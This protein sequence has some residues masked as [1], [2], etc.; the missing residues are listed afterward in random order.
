MATRTR[1]RETASVAGGDARIEEDLDKKAVAWTFVAKVDPSQFDAERSLSNNA[2]F[3]AIDEKRVE[4]YTEAMKRGDAFP[5]VVAHK[6]G[7]LFVIT[8][9]NH[10]LQAAI[11]AGKPL[12]V[13]D[14]TGAESQVIVLLSFEANTRHGLPTSEEERI[15]QALYLINNGATIPAAAA[16]VNLP[17]KTV[18]RASQQA[19]ADRRFIDNNIPRLTIE[20]LGVPVKGRLSQISTDEG[21]VA[22]VDLVVRAKI[23]S[24][25]VFKLV[26]E[27]N[28]LRSSDKQVAYVRDLEE[29]YAS[30]IQG[31]GGGV[32]NGKRVMGPRAKVG[33]SLTN[34]LSLPDDLEELTSHWVGPEREEQAKRMKAAA[35]RLN[36]LSRALL[37]S[38]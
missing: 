11:K 35:K 30:S 3:T 16:A 18:D 23:G 33:S 34:I 22:M 7:N 13:Y 6:Q 5:P 32:L 26:T 8:D 28:E 37:T 9:G 24:N 1:T 4:Q 25:D 2:R 10:R 12:A 38:T 19:T 17:R 15:Q 14:I 27:I 31:T 20:K 36:E 29:Q 21:F